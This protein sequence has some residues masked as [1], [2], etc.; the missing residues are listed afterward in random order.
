MQRTWRGVLG[1]ALMVLGLAGCGQHDVNTAAVSDA[2][3]AAYQSK[4]LLVLRPMN[5]PV[6]VPA[7]D[8]VAQSG[9]LHTPEMFRG[10]WTLFYVGYSFCPDI[11][12]TELTALAE[13]MPLLKKALPSAHWQVVFLS[14]DPERD[15]PK[16]LA[17]YAHYFDPQFIGMTG[18]RAAIDAVTGALKAGYRIAPHAQGDVTY[19]I[20]HDTGYRLISPQGKMV[21]LLPSPHDPAAMT[22][23]LVEIFREAVQ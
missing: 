3:L 4:D 21:A 7:A 16:R 23:A 22:Q 11:C 13:M 20:D 6:A 2:R 1:L 5:P 19:E 17:E 9:P 12:P 15:N 8:F 14:V 10:H 18:E